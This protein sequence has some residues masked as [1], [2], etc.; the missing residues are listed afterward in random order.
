MIDG[1]S[2]P[3]P[4]RTLPKPCAA[5]KLRLVLAFGMADRF[6]FQSVETGILL[7]NSNWATEILKIKDTGCGERR[8]TI[9]I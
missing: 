9:A 7:A 5:N 4:C 1:R 6:P 2:T 8:M 3:D